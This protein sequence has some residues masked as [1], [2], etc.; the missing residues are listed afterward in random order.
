LAVEPGNADRK[1]IEVAHVLT[2]TP[3]QRMVHVLPPASLP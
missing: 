1:L 3:L 2:L